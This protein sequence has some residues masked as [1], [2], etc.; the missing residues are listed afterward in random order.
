MEEFSSSEIDSFLENFERKHWEAFAQAIA[1]GDMMAS[2]RHLVAAGNV[3]YDLSSNA[4]S[5][6][7]VNSLNWAMVSREEQ[8]EKLMSKGLFTHALPFYLSCLED[9]LRSSG[10]GPEQALKAELM[11]RE[12]VSVYIAIARELNPVGD[13]SFITPH[14]TYEFLEIAY[15]I[16]DQVD[17]VSERK[18]IQALL[19]YYGSRISQ[20]A[21]KMMAFSIDKMTDVNYLT[22]MDADLIESTAEEAMEDFKAY[23]SEWARKLWELDRRLGKPVDWDIL[24]EPLVSKVMDEYP[25]GLFEDERLVFIQRWLL[26]H[27]YHWTLNKITKVKRDMEWIQA[28]QAMSKFTKYP[29]DSADKMAYLLNGASR[30]YLIEAVNSAVLKLLKGNTLSTDPDVIAASLLL[31]EVG[32]QGFEPIEPLFSVDE[33][34][35]LV[36]VYREWWGSIILGQISG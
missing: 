3:V 29:Y 13:K 19:D 18:S 2:N 11:I 5:R 16:A 25:S 15:E 31:L 32:I 36:T 10:Q 27:G 9:C 30:D 6:L 23:S 28:V 7:A 34:D 26:E 22:Q 21:S 24:P 35:R 4:P 20:H 8:G 1:K 14:G 12:V 33:I 17:P